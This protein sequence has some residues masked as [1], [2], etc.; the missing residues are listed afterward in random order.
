MKILGS[1]V[2]GLW[3]RI[4]HLIGEGANLPGAHG[5]S[6]PVATSTHVGAPDAP[7][8]STVAQRTPST[9]TAA[10]PR[11]AH[12]PD[13]PPS[14]SSPEA[15][16]SWERNPEAVPSSSEKEEG[17]SSNRE[18]EEKTPG[19]PPIPSD[20][21]PTR[22]G[23]DPESEQSAPGTRWKHTRHGAACGG[24]WGLSGG[25][26]RARPPRLRARL[27]FPWI[28]IR[29]DPDRIRSRSSRRPGRG[30]STRA[31]GAPALG[32]LGLGIRV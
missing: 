18:E 20:P 23:S 30:G 10:G 1:G 7:T 17:P 14:D 9:D 22:S 4:T 2:R 12:S 19:P 25:P 11:G 26:R 5:V 24:V 16:P 13:P 21:D 3:S 28:R 27:R 8:D 32:L 6:N 31:R 15:L 29:P